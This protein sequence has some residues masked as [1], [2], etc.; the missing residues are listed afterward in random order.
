MRTSDEAHAE[1]ERDAAYHWQ[2][3]KEIAVLLEVQARKLREMC[4]DFRPIH[5]LRL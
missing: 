1:V 2:K 3:I 5:D 4:E